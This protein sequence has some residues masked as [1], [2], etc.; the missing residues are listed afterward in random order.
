MKSFRLAVFD[1]TGTTATDRN[2]VRECFI[3]AAHNT[4]LQYTL[5]Q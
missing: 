5:E 1:M 2:E 4:G 3:Q